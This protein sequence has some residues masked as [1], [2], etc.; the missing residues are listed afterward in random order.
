M[1]TTKHTPVRMED[2]R[3]VH[4]PPSRTVLRTPLIHGD[5]VGVRFDFV[6]GQTR[7]FPVPPSVAR[8]ALA[9]GYSDKLG[10]LLSSAQG[11]APAPPDPATS[12]A[13]LEGAHAAISSTGRWNPSRERSPA[14]GG[15]LLAALIEYT[16][17]TPDALQAILAT[18]SEKEKARLRLSPELSPIIARI[19]AARRTKGAPP[20]GSSLLGDFA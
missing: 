11:G 12:I 15:L 6:T 18:K 3:T 16:G 1:T 5:A 2:G 4:F 10:A 20:E 17:K 14:T 9:R 8:E 7:T 13:I 19:R